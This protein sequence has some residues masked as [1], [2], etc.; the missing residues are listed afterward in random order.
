[1]KREF[2]AALAVIVCL[3]SVGCQIVRDE[4]GYITRIDLQTDQ[5]GD[6][7]SETTLLA[8]ATVQYT[9]QYKE[10]R[11]ALKEAERAAEAAR[12]A[13]ERAAAEARAEKWRQTIAEALSNL[14]KTNDEM[15]S[16]QKVQ[17]KAVKKLDPEKVEASAS[18]EAPVQTSAESPV[19]TLHVNGG[20]LLLTS[21]G[22]I[23]GNNPQ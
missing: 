21:S 5:I 2:L 10:G 18:A 9:L 17:N 4:R 6:I 22:I 20:D 1:M 7:A 8:Q 12:T 3:A 13:E 23:I 19:D 14:R 15:K 16:L 11:L